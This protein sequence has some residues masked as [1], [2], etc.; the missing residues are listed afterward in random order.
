MPFS[1]Y[2]KKFILIKGIIFPNILG[3]FAIDYS[4]FIIKKVFDFVFSAVNKLNILT[5]LFYIIFKV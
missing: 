2:F 4:G 5:S 3:F 1:P